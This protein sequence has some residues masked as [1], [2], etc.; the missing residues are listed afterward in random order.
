[1][2]LPQIIV[3]Y[4]SQTTTCQLV[5]SWL[6]GWAKLSDHFNSARI[7]HYNG[8]PVIGQTWVCSTTTVFVFVSLFGSVK[9]FEVICNGSSGIMYHSIQ[10]S[11]AKINARPHFIECGIPADS[12]I[13]ILN[14]IE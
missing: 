9:S 4:E 5:C 1:M 8:Y 13:L 7:L 2:L 3:L 12:A 10:L 11:Y 14:L 6:P